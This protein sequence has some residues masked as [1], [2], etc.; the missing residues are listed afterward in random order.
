MQCLFST[1][2]TTHACEEEEEEEATEEE[3]QAWQLLC[4][5]ALVV[6]WRK[7]TNAHQRQKPYVKLHQPQ[8]SSKNGQVF[9]LSVPA[10][11]PNC[12]RER[13]KK[14]ETDQEEEDNTITSLTFFFGSIARCDGKFCRKGEI[15]KKTQKKITVTKL[16]LNQS[17][18]VLKNSHYWPI[19]SST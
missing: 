5:K 7:I 15:K 19:V 6:P 14:G 9:Q 3:R 2:S 17:G 10:G 18:P 16:V 13:K 4:E 11:T 1:T 12:Q 8:S